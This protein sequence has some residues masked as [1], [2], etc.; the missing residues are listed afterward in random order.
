MRR[1]VTKQNVLRQTTWIIAI[2]LKKARKPRYIKFFY[3]WNNMKVRNER[4]IN[5]GNFKLSSESSIYPKI[6][7]PQNMSFSVV[8]THILY[9]TGLMLLYA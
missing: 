3:F 6:S 9:I 7:L 5:R 2:F 4:S 8:A 1:H